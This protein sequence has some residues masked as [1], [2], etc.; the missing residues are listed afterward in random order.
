MSFINQS[1]MLEISLDINVDREK[2]PCLK[3]TPKNPT[4]QQQQQKR[5]YNQLLLGGGELA[6]TKDK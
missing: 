4:N 6:S 3:P 5:I 2:F 1:G